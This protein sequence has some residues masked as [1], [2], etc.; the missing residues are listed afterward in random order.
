MDVSARAL[1]KAWADEA[2]KQA[3]KVVAAESY[4]SATDK[5]FVPQ[6]SEFK[7]AGADWDL[8]TGA[9]PGPG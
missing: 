7:S 9:G 3:L 1:G 5:N 4:N 8:V 2:E 6:L